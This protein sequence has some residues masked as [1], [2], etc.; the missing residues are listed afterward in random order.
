MA[1]LIARN[2]TDNFERAIRNAPVVFLTG[3][4]QV[5]KSTLVKQLIGSRK[6][7]QYITFDDPNLVMAA[8]RDPAA[9]LDAYAQHR[10]VV[11][12]EVQRVPELYL[13]LKASVDEDRRP[14]RFILTGSTSALFLPRLADALVGRMQ[15][16]NLR[17]LSISELNRSR[18]TFLD[19]CFSSQP[20]P[21][22]LLLKPANKQVLS[23]F[24]VRGGFPE[25]VLADNDEKSDAWFESYIQTIVSRDVRDLAD[26]DRL[27]EFPQLFRLLAGRSATLTNLS[28]ISRTA[29]IPLNTLKRY[30]AIL[31]VV[32]LYEPL[33]PWHTNIGKRLVK[34]PKSFLCDSGLLC[35]MLGVGL[36]ITESEYYGRIL[37]NFV[38]CELRKQLGWSRIKAE[39]Y[40]WR[41][42]EGDEVD[43]VLQSKSGMLIGIEVK[44]KATISNSDLK[45]LAVLNEKMG[46]KLKRGVILYQGKNIVPFGKNMLALPVSALWQIT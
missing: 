45:G 22:Q 21:N 10:T 27:L 41:T 34:S 12:D 37:E 29:A 15:I 4:R 31:E 26:V 24:I 46:E 14:G 39:V 28:E 13:P 16:L 9:F 25:V 32:C 19:W 23:K 2:I 30:L 33:A 35:H 43:F 1:D 7:A 6:D 44:A 18:E 11:F 8:R 40:H 36:N 20:V 42:H 38:L 17:P 5:G 3:A